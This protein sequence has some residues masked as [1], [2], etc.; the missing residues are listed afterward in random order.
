MAFPGVPHV[1][2]RSAIPAHILGP[3][4]H[5]HLRAPALLLLCVRIRVATRTHTAYYSYSI[6]QSACSC[7][8]FQPG[9]QGLSRLSGCS[10]L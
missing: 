5:P 6:T 9:P 10:S 8:S 4:L 3:N 7:S 2:T 1:R